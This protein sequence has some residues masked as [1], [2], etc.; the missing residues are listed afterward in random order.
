LKD[1]T[2][3]NVEQSLGDD[4]HNIVTVVM[5]ELGT[6]VNGAMLWAQ[7]THTKLE[8]TFLAAMAALPEWDEPLNSQVKEYCNGLGQFVRANDD[9]H[10]E[11]ERY[12]GD[13]GLE[14]KEKRWIS[15]MP[16]VHK[17]GTS[18]V[19]PVLVDSSLL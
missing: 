17:K 13:R 16:K 19:G 18:E 12:F 15:L 9:W 3:Y 4:S 8:K 5:N 10:F 1:I 14:I 7:D 6:D 2:S 11:S